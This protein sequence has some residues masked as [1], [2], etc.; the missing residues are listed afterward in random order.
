MNWDKVKWGI[1]LALIYWLPATIV[2]FIIIY[3]T[4]GLFSDE[5]NI[6]LRPG[7]FIGLVVGFAVGNGFAIL[8]S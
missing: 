5:I 4:G 8:G 6:F 1:G 2:L 7:Y 3:G